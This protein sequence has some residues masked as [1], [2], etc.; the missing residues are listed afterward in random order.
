MKVHEDF[1][2]GKLTLVFDTGE[3]VELS[4]KESDEF[5]NWFAR[6]TKEAENEQ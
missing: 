4:E 3:K 5:T 6:K 1:T 2:T